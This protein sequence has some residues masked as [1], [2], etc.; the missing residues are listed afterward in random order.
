LVLVN[1]TGDKSEFTCVDIFLVKTFDTKY[2]R[3]LIGKNFWH[4][5][6]HPLDE[7]LVKDIEFK[8]YFNEGGYKKLNAMLI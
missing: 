6:C 8:I 7:L 4:S 2:E 5:K 1:L 3:P